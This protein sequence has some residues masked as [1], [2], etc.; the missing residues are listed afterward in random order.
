[1]IK[2]LTIASILI[3]TAVSCLETER[4][5]DYDY[6]VLRDDGGGIITISFTGRNPPDLNIPVSGIIPSNT[7]NYIFK[8]LNIDLVSSDAVNLEKFTGSRLDRSKYVIE[9]NGRKITL[10]RQDHGCKDD[11]TGKWYDCIM[12]IEIQTQ[13]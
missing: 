11:F 13:K 5:T 6:E 7:I 3:I 10:I 2:V 1:M 8:R 9:E 4:T 12:Q